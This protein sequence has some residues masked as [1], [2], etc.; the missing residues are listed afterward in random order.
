TPDSPAGASHNELILPLHVAGRVIGALAAER[1]RSFRLTENE[2]NSLIALCS[3][4][5]IGI[6]NARSYERQAAL[7]EENRRLLE[8]SQAAFAD[9]DALN[10]RLT[11]EGWQ[12]YMQRLPAD[13]VVQD[14][15][16]STGPVNECLPLMS[17]AMDMGELLIAQEQD[18]S[19]MAVPIVVRGEVIGSLGLEGDPHHRWTSDQ[20][21]ILKDIAEHLALS[22]ENARLI[23]ETQ[24]ALSESRRLAERE[25]RRAAISDQLHRTTDIQGILRIAAEELLRST[26]S[27]RAVVRLSRSSEYR[28]R[29]EDSAW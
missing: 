5:A 7:A 12:E 8:Q 10:R 3:Q 13:V 2:T 11:R 14:L 26:G 25:S 28:G 21:A 18:Q 23:E 4:V 24:T 6:Q 17:E 15:D 9:L 22:V 27:S 29:P 1:K 16:S 20:V 19:A